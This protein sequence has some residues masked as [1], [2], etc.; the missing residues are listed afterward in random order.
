MAL[1][2][3]CESYL[4]VQWSCHG[5]S[6]DWCF[7]CCCLPAQFNNLASR[8]IMGQ[9]SQVFSGG[10]ITSTKHVLTASVN[11]LFENLIILWTNLSI[12]FVEITC[13]YNLISYI[14]PIYITIIKKQLIGN[15]EYQCLQ[16]H[17]KIIKYV[18]T[19]SPATLLGTPVQLLGNS[20]C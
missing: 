14:F 13:I 9:K 10:S 8:K 20:N 17:Y 11:Q 4:C 5:C 7:N 16:F 6:T 15:G 1:G 2:W 3:S 19:H 18:Y 12:Y